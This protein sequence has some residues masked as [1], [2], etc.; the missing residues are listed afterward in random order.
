MPKWTKKKT[1]VR[2]SNAFN[3]LAVPFNLIKVFFVGSK[4][5]GKRW[6]GVGKGKERERVG[7]VSISKSLKRF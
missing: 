3:F 2:L 4:G 1:V 6:W 5:K 7:V